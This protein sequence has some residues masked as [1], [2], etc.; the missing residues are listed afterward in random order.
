MFSFNDDCDLSIN[1][2]TNKVTLQM[3]ALSK[4]E[5]DVLLIYSEDTEYYCSQINLPCL[6]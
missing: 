1:C 5:D 4:P 6:M 3:P 2:N